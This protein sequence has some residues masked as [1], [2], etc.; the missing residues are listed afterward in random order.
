MFKK[1]VDN[2]KI[3]TSIFEGPKTFM[4]LQHLKR[5]FPYLGIFPAIQFPIF[6]ELSMSRDIAV[7]EKL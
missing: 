7:R 6:L 4:G 3:I 5:T 1:N 2:I